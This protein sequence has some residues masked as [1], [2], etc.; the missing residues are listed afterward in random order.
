MR[1]ECYQSPEVRTGQHRALESEQPSF[2]LMV[3][4]LKVCHTGDLWD[5]LYYTVLPLPPGVNLI[6]QVKGEVGL[7]MSLG[8]I[9]MGPWLG[10]AV[11]KVIQTPK[12]SGF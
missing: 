9:N 10:P 8:D 11:L 4:W 2:L 3:S 7:G 5:A 1:A 12:S 6:S